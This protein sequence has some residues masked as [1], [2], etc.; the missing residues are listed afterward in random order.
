MSGNHVN[1]TF[2]MVIYTIWDKRLTVEG[3]N[4]HVTPDRQPLGLFRPL[5]EFD[6]N[7]CP[8]GR[9]DDKHDLQSYNQ[10]S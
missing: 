8:R 2:N 1:Q 3:H 9:T 4:L 10:T 7:N 6:V 5:M